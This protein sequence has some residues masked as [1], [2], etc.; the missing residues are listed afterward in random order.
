[1]T[2]LEEESGMIRAGETDSDLEVT[3]EEED[4]E[5]MPYFVMRRIRPK[6]DLER[7]RVQRPALIP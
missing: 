7:V 1:M 6:K 4:F 3:S 2:R 5:V